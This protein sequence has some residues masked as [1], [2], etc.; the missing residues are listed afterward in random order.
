MKAAVSQHKRIGVLTF[1]G[2]FS[3]K[4]AFCAEEAVVGSN[5]LFASEIST[6]KKMVDLLV[7]FS[8]KYSFQVLGGFLVLAIGWFFS[9]FVAKMLQKFLEKHKVDVTV[10][11]FIITIM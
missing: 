3:S 4:V 8:L 7:E 6:A 1:L 11:K 9:K 10:S 2:V 5:A